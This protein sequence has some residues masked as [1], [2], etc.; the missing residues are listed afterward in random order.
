MADHRS[1]TRTVPAGSAAARLALL[2][3]GLALLAAMPA[4]ALDSGGQGQARSL[5][6][7]FAKLALDTS[8]SNFLLQSGQISQQAYQRRLQKDRAELPLLQQALARLPADQQNVARQQ[9]AVTFNQGM[10]DL[11]QRITAWQKRGSPQGPQR[12]GRQAA[13]S[14]TVPPTYVSPPPYTPPRQSSRFERLLLLLL[15]GAGIGAGVIVVARRR[16]AGGPAL[17]PDAEEITSRSIATAL[18]ADPECFPAMPAPAS[19]VPR[20]VATAAAT[21]GTGDAKERLLGEQTAKYQATLTAAMDELTATQVALEERKTLP[22][23]LRKDLG[24]I[25]ALVHERLKKL[26]REETPGVGKAIGSALLLMPLWRRFWRGG[27]GFKVLMV[28]GAWWLL[29][30]IARMM[31][32][33]LYLAPVLIYLLIAVPV[34]FFFARRAQ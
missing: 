23:L 6:A 27:I 32:A 16:R 25:G 33:G 24:R 14:Y 26:L 5:G 12:A 34:C 17:P 7:A 1:R 15:A 28:I 11:R 9:A 10:T 2:L 19:V 3:L 31:V 13:Q 18:P 4:S 22:E 30:G 8:E 29:G 20:P 21:P